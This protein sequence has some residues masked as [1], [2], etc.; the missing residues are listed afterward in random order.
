MYENVT[1]GQFQ[2]I[3]ELRDAFL[4]LSDTKVGAVT[5]NQTVITS[6]TNLLLLSSDHF[7]PLPEYFY[8]DSLIDYLNTLP[9][10]LELHKKLDSS[11]SLIDKVDKNRYDEID[12]E[13]I[14]AF[15]TIIKEIKDTFILK[16]V[17]TQEL[18]DSFPLIEAYRENKHL[19]YTQLAKANLRLT[20]IEVRADKCRHTT[21]DTVWWS[22]YK[23]L[24]STLELVGIDSSCVNLD[25]FQAGVDKSLHTRIYEIERETKKEVSQTLKDLIR[26]FDNLSY[27]LDLKVLVSDEHIAKAKL[28]LVELELY[29]VEAGL[30]QEGV[31]RRHIE[32]KKEQGYAL[33]LVFNNREVEFVG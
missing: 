9:E 30:L 29:A 4:L 18:Y 17:F 7:N 11:L 10:E 5:D 22:I 8:C 31:V 3:R 19:L 32:Y 14:L 25:Y 33:D 27:Y 28:F 6:I 26:Y 20:D 15:Q 24:C 1:T 13:V 12:D 16:E 23:P 21:L 2:V